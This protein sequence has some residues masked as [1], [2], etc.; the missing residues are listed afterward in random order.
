MVFRV[1]V[2][3]RN[4]LT[5]KF[6]LIT[7][8]QHPMNLSPLDELVANRSLEACYGAFVSAPSRNRYVGFEVAQ[9]P[10]SVGPSMAAPP[11]LDRDG[12]TAHVIK[13]IDEGR[14][15]REVGL[16]A[17][18]KF[19]DG[20]YNILTVGTGNAHDGLVEFFRN[21]KSSGARRH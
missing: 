7:S 10:R 2:L 12:M 15:P 8:G 3:R 14:L 9:R 21:H 5:G 16:E 6:P 11:S 18:R 13:A 20:N 1:E 4:S 17:L 19:Y